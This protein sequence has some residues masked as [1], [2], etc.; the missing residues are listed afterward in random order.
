MRI[1]PRNNVRCS[2]SPRSLDIR[3]PVL[4]LSDIWGYL[5]ASLLGRPTI[6]V[7]EVTQTNKQ[8]MIMT[9]FTNPLLYFV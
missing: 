1:R 3:F 9:N 8:V 4:R 6:F 7:N 2:K 5:L